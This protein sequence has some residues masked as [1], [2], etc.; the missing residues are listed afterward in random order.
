M[1]ILRN[2]IAFLVGVVVGGAVNMG[3]ILLGPLIIPPPAGVNPGD[4]QSI[5]QSIHLFGPEHFVTPLLAHA[6]GT[7]TGALVAYLLA[8][9]RHKLLAGAVGLFFLA[10]GLLAASMIPAPAWFLAL[11]LIVAYLPMALLAI[12]VGNKLLAKSGSNGEA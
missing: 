7:L 9:S 12:W 6:T 3:I 4:T 5:A 8:S 10:G 11:D 2:T 1:T